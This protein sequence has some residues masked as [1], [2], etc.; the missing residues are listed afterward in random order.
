MQVF[1]VARKNFFM[2][3]RLAK[4]F[5]CHKTIHNEYDG[6]VLPSEFISR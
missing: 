2:W 6:N 5:F 3:R 1:V 4:L